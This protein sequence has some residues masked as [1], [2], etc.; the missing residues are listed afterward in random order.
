M[1]EAVSHLEI[2]LEQ[3]NRKDKT[4]FTY[5][6]YI[7]LEVVEGVYNETN[8]HKLMCPYIDNVLGDAYDEMIRKEGKNIVMRNRVFVK[9]MQ[10]EN[11]KANTIKPPPN[12]PPPPP[13]PPNPNPRRTIKNKK[14][15]K[16]K[17]GGTKKKKKTKE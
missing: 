1:K 7:N 8:Y 14:K 11:K 5:E 3:I 13:P 16:R 4:S 17:S 10:P 6:A 9:A 2:G 12:P 15:K